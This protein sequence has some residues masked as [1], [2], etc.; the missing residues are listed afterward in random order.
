M[1]TEADIASV[2]CSRVDGED[3]AILSLTRVFAPVHE[4][5]VISV[6][7]FPES[8]G[9]NHTLT[10]DFD[11]DGQPHELSAFVILGEIE[12]VATD[13]T[14]FGNTRATTFDS[15]KKVIRFASLG[16][17]TVTPVDS[18]EEI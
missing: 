11:R 4:E 3:V 17:Y 9:R 2:R 7:A 10:L 14:T 15:V 8:A 1:L 16:G 18:K 13:I 5:L 6:A 12:Y